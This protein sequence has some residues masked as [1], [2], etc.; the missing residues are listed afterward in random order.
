MS[1]EQQKQ[2]YRQSLPLAGAVIVDVGANVGELSELFF[3]RCGPKGRVISVEPHPENIKALERRIRRAKG[4]RWSLKR[5]AVSNRQGHVTLRTLKTKHGN[6]SMVADEGDLE[7]A[8]IPL[9]KLSPDA[10]VVKLDV[11]GHEYA[12]LPEAVPALTR[13][14]AWALELHMVAGE[15][16]ER[17]LGLLADHGFGL[18]TAG[19]RKG[20][21]GRWLSVE[22]PPTL[23]WDEV[24][25]LPAKRDGLDTVFKMLHVIARR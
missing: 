5:C 19:Q 1:L 7:V 22:I 17:T 21:P 2:W 25:G 10:T 3:Q 9:S 23:T 12:I 6:N 8:C 14:K 16:L 15:P 11:E 13:V 24:P 20:E 18:V 4:R